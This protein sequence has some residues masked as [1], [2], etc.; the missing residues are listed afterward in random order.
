MKMVLWNWE[1][2]PVTLPEKD[3]NI[4]EINQF[5]SS[6]LLISRNTIF[7]MLYSGAMVHE[8]DY[9]KT[10]PLNVIC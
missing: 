4:N 2:S 8:K 6:R 1:N 9:R 10:F 5:N 7:D 3:V